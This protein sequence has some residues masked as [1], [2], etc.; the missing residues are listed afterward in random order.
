MSHLQITFHWK[1]EILLGMRINIFTFTESDDSSFLLCSIKISQSNFRSKKIRDVDKRQHFPFF[2][3]TNV[4][5]FW[6]LL[7]SAKRHFVNITA[8]LIKLPRNYWN[9]AWWKP[10]WKQFY[11]IRFFLQVPVR[12]HHLPQN[13]KNRN[14]IPI[15][16]RSQIQT[17]STST[18]N[19]K[20]CRQTD[21]KYSALLCWHLYLLIVF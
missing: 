5:P 6:Q 17:P 14:A 3:E 12:Y 11:P 18:S 13:I 20:N 10:V 16:K 4:G 9:N 21:M 19:S 8:D 1:N 7:E 2:F 15:E